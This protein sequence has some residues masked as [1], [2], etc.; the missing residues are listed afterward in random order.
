MSEKTGISRRQFL[1]GAAIT[2]AA[3]TVPVLANV[4]TAAAASPMTALTQGDPT[5]VPLDAKALARQG[6]EIYKGKWSGQSA[7]CEGTFWPI[8]GELGNRFPATWGTFP[9]GVFNF[10]GGGINSWR[11]QCG[12]TNAGPAVLKLVTNNGAAIDEYMRWYEKTALPTAACYADYATGTWTPGGNATGGWGAAA[13]Q[14]PIPFVQTP[15]SA[16]GSTLCHAS[17]TAWRVAG[18][19]FEAQ[20]VG[21]QSD[22]CGKLV[23]DSVFKLATMINAWMAGT[24]FA[25]ALDPEVASCGEGTGSAC[26]GKTGNAY[27]KPYAQAKMKCSPCHE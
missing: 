3:S 8:I 18:G 1:T 14:L 26:H 10:G 4:S 20:N 19:D 11:A 6:Y 17:L 25:G 27:G 22:R 24:N 21:A 23:Y 15:A 13:N 5:W 2:V 16:A 9:K 12:C 7:C